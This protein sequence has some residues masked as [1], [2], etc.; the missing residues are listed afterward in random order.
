M[1][2]PTGSK[3]TTKLPKIV[4]TDEKERLEYIAALLLEIV[5]QEFQRREEKACNQTL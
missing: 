5:E 1:S 2:R 4:R 3:N